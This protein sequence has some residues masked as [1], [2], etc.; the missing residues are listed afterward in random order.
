M[1]SA[2]LSEARA[3]NH[4]VT[5]CKH[6]DAPTSN[7]V[8]FCCSGC[9]AAYGLTKSSGC[10]TPNTKP[11]CPSKTPDGPYAAFAEAQNDNDHEDDGTHYQLTLSVKGIHCASCIQLIENALSAEA[12]VTHARVNMSTNRLSIAWN[13]PIERANAL[14]EKVNQLGYPVTPFDAKAGKAITHSEERSLIRAI[15]I[16]G[17]AMGNLMLL[18]VGLWSS[19]SETMGIATRE[20][21][22]WISAII[23]LPAI[24]FA[25][26]PFFHSALGVLKH[27]RTNMDVPISLAVI[28]ASA[29]S[30]FETIRQGE[31][32]YFDSAVML[33]FFL[34]IGRYLDARARG[35]AKES[36]QELLS[37]LS[38]T[39]TVIGDDG[40]HTTLPLR[41]LR[42][43]MVILVAMG[44]TIPA[45][46]I[47]SRGESE[48][49]MSL[50][51]GETIPNAVRPGDAV[52]A[53]TLNLS[54]PI[55]ITLS[56][57][58]DDSLLSDIVKL[59]EQAEQ[60]QAHYV[61]L[62][63]RAARLY[64]PVVHTMGALTFLG[65]WLGMGIEWQPALLIAI[66]VLIITCPCAL[67]L[68]V[69]VVQVL[70]SGRLM[71]RGILL[72]SGDALE[73]LATIDTAV[74][75]KTGTLTLGKPTLE[76]GQ[77]DTHTL[78]LAASIAAHSK[79]PLSRAI[80]AAYDGELLTTSEIQEHP[81]KGLEA[82]MDGKTVRLGSRTWCGDADAPHHAALELWLACEGE[83]PLCFTFSD[84]LRD[85]AKRVIA[86]LQQEGIQTLLLSGDREQAV[87]SMA[88]HVG[89]QDY[90]AAMTPIEKTQKLETLKAKGHRVLM[91][92]DG[93]NDAP[94]LAAADISI[95]PS[96]ALD[97]AQNTADI[98]FQGEELG[99]ILTVWQTA[100]QSTMLVKENFALAV[101]Y[102]IIAIPLAVLG[103]VTPL[104]A[105]IA[106]S[107][108]SL[109]V[110]GNSFRLNL[111]KGV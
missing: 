98:V 41:E 53:G 82:V 87:T 35:K 80:S 49:D 110:I 63:D 48:L 67:G 94:S 20:L 9:E 18:S 76:N 99:A 89:I 71:K 21:F 37:L 54:A 103:Y 77:Y 91:V 4:R 23:A 64:T 46:G 15:A 81:G 79:H 44:E 97:I 32:V 12:D 93:L 24:L 43:G 104:V 47:V 106:M 61:R 66:T 86:A 105:A 36:A 83:P 73:R 2:K 56:K 109:L 88:E 34:L 39:A 45:D 19:S 90:H 74:F 40:R 28:L 111:N 108:S 62:A 84:P 102:N 17:F 30:L 7:G 72:K 5:H 95:S 92:G 75:D 55:H 33:L 85:D 13:G 78:Q 14:A 96:S 57:A 38:S 22:H 60:G 26:Q 50:I 59:M 65:W 101:V 6:C 3:A 16:A 58:S 27:G 1:E 52:L 25:G 31:H 42:E 100:K 107:G 8:E 11:C 10:S 70:A 29:M 51:T 68:A 69:P